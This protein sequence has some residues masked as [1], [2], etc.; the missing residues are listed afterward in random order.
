MIRPLTS[1]RQAGQFHKGR[2]DGEG[3]ESG[4]RVG[5]PGM[6]LSLHRAEEAKRWKRQ[7]LGLDSGQP[8][9][10][11]SEFLTVQKGLAATRCLS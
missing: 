6:A 8:S 11:Y 1:G 10:Q 5:Q 2:K 3:P 9:G 7:Q 4:W